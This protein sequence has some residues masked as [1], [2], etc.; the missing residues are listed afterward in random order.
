VKGHHPGTYV[1]NS[2]IKYEL[3]I[4]YFISNLSDMDVS[5]SFKSVQFVTCLKSNS[6]FKSVQLSISNNKNDLI[7]ISFNTELHTEQPQ[8]GTLI[9]RTT[10]VI[11][12]DDSVLSRGWSSL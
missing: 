11:V 9:F 7:P 10:A 2:Y 5:A 12:K 4:P 8:P 1:K 3:I 6:A